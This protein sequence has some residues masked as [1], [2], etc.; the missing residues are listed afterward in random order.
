MFSSS[1]AT[2]RVSSCTLSR[3]N[4]KSRS[5]QLG[6]TTGREPPTARTREEPTLP[7]WTGEPARE[8]TGQGH[9]ERS[10]PLGSSISRRGKADT[11]GGNLQPT[12]SH[13]PFALSDEG[14][15]RDSGQPQGKSRVAN[16]AAD[17]T[18]ESAGREQT[19]GDAGA[20]PIAGGGR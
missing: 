13:I 7:T 12:G 15:L 17:S 1:N 5:N 9:D 3:W 11:L 14:I 8:S 10:A 2:W 19:G 16:P 20:L 4:K 6:W 18:G